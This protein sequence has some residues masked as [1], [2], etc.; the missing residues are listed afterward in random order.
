MPERSSSGV[1]RGLARLRLKLSEVD[2]RSVARSQEPV[3]TFMRD[4]VVAAADAGQVT[5]PDPEGATYMVLAVRTAYITSLTLGND[6]AVEVPSVFVLTKFCLDGLGASVDDAWLEAVNEKLR[7]PRSR[8][9]TASA[10][11]R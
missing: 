7:L 11:T 5:T 9:R 10:K 6:T 1:D 2:P 8:S 3:T 4:L